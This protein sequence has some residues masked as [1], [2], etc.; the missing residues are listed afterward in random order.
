MAVI[1]TSFPLG[2]IPYS[3]PNKCA[4][5]MA[6]HDRLLASGTQLHTELKSTPDSRE[7]HR[8]AVSCMQ[9][10]QLPAAAS[11]GTHV[12][13]LHNPTGSGCVPGGG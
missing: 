12:W 8:P 1:Y 7:L 11:Q 5:H 2:L 3:T 4:P 13:H 10:A 9:A 6:P